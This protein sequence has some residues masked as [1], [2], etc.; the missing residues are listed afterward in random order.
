MTAMTVTSKG[1][2]TLKRDLLR[3]L[4][5]APGQQL[6]VDKLANG[7]LVLHA[8]PSQGIASFAGC[9][10]PPGKA[11]NVEEM[12]AVIAHAWSAGK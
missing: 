9:L 8:R 2:I 7:G 1:Q 10:P 4:G 12:N 11:L 3:H 6:T 5:I